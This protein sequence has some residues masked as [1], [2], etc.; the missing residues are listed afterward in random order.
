MEGSQSGKRAW[1][2]ASK[3]E[4]RSGQWKPSMSEYTCIRVNGGRDSIQKKYVA[5][6]A[7]LTMV[8]V[9]T[10]GG[11]KDHHPML[12]VD[13]TWNIELITAGEV[14]LNA[15]GAAQYR[16]TYLCDTPLRP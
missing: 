10:A 8:L 9:R 1:R 2:I 14:R 4:T 13:V 6:A 7:R 11:V 16:L 3:A 5:S 12:G 15:G